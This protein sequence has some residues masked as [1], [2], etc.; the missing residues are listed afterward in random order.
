L[1][2]LGVLFWVGLILMLLGA[3]QRRQKQTTEDQPEPALP[4]DMQSA[5]I[6]GGTANQE[7]IW[8]L[9]LYG[10]LLFIGL[11]LFCIPVFWL[12]W[13]LPF[14]K[15]AKPEKHSDQKAPADDQAPLP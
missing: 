8:G 12:P 6:R 15:V 3:S 2:V 13:V 11:L 1:V 7:L 5:A 4:P 14:C 10:F 9:N